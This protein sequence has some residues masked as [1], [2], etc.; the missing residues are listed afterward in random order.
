MDTAVDWVHRNRKSLL[1]GSVV[2]VAGVAFVV[3]SAGAGVIV[4]APA[5]FLASPEIEPE[6]YM[7][8]VSP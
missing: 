8:E 2:V 1:I 6:S 7:A 4:L 5:V 3:I